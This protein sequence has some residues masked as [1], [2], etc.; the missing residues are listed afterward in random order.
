MEK[1]SEKVWAHGHEEGAHPDEELGEEVAT[2]E[3]EEPDVKILLQKAP[4]SAIPAKVKPMKATLVNEPIDEPG[5]LYEVKW[6]G[7]C[8][9][10]ILGKKRGTTHLAE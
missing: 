1:T 6:D 10:A 2:E 8:A 7:Y 3:A 9:V 5:W 4:K